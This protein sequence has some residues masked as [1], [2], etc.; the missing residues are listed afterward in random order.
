M[1]TIAVPRDLLFEALGRTYTDE[2]FEELCFDYGLELDEITS[3]KAMISKEQGAEK[4]EGASDVV[5]YKVEVPANRY[6][7]LCLEGLVRAL[8]VFL[9]KIDHP[10]YVATPPADGN[11]E[12]LVIMPA[13]A[14]VRPFAVGAVLRD[15][16]FTPE[17]Y[18]SFIDLQDKLHHNIG[19]RRALVSMGTHDL[20]TIQGPFRYDAEPPEKIKFRPL[21]QT[22][23][24][25]AVEQMELY[26]KD[27]HLRHYLPIIR[28]KPVY[29][30]LYDRNNVVLSMPPIINGDHTKI[31]L[32]TKNVFIDITGTDL[33]KVQ[34]SLD[35]LVSTFSQYCSKPFQIES[36]EVTRP[37]G[38]KMI[39]PTLEYRHEQLPVDLVN[40][41]IGINENADA[42]AK[43]LTRMCL[44]SEVVEGN[45][46]LRVEVPPTRADVIHACDVIE[47][48]AVAYG[49]NNL[50][51]RI[52]HTNTIGDQLPINKLTDLLRQEMASAGFTEVLTFALCSSEDIS[53]KLRKDMSTTKAVTISNPKTL[54]FQ[55]ARTCLLPGVLK[56]IS[57]NRKMPLPIKA[58]EISDIVVQT[59][60]RDVGAQNHR[61]F[62]AVHYNKSPG[63]EVIH[64]LLDRTMQLLEVPFS[65]EDGYHL[66]AVEDATYFPGRCAD[67]CFKGQS[68][69]RIGVL[70]P[71]VVTKFE[72]TNPCAALEITIE[73][74]L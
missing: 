24:Y 33:N 69:G 10:R 65:K 4:A 64:G 13:T 17:N 53:D 6:D 40:S 36:V 70:H 12:R 52:P 68:I 16:T 72:L 25:T 30:I 60:E 50:V 57:N 1:P 46:Q 8:L 61:H 71:E 2:E 59:K 38:S 20:D 21:N 41:R 66:Q 28:D 18:K 11:M 55:V 45:K 26:S 74:F 67:V 54:D 29:P 31:T 43:L 9:Q 15:I 3:E 73:P 56:T 7:L 63:F 47:D 35:I 48:V 42:L 5:I 14:Q 27:S 37:D 49:F 58:F 22:K 62:C 23:E 51:E 32:E 39:T 34:T 44:N 19:R